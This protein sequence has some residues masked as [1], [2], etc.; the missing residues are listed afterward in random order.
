MAF[1]AMAEL[2]L[3]LPYLRHSSVVGD[4]CGFNVSSGILCGPTTLVP[5]QTGGLLVVCE[6]PGFANDGFR[7]SVCAVTGA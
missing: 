5:K 4:P 1:S 2:Q 7:Y 6:C 3:L